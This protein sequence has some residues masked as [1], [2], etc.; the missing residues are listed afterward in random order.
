MADAILQQFYRPTSPCQYSDLIDYGIQRCENINHCN[1]QHSL[2][3]G[4][5][6][7]LYESAL[8]YEFFV[9]CYMCRDISGF[10]AVSSN[11]GV[12]L[13]SPG[14]IGFYVSNKR[15]GIELTRNSSLL[16]RATFSGLY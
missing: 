8:Q 6:D 12:K 10:D 5:D 3:L 13:G 2:S 1:L 4:V 7:R 14:Y 15:W 11:A 9:S 16:K